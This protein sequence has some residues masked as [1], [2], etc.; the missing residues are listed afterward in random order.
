MLFMVV[1]G[2]F[3]S[4]VDPTKNVDVVVGADFTVDGPEQ[5]ISKGEGYLATLRESRSFRSS[6]PTPGR[7]CQNPI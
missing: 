6:D 3:T 4:L 2:E 1:G 7:G 5:I